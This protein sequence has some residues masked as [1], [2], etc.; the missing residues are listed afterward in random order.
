MVKGIYRKNS[1]IMQ[2][3][4]KLQQDCFVWFHNTYPNLRGTM[5][6]VHNNPKNARHGTVL[7]GLGLVAGVSDMSFL[8][9]GKFYAIEFKTDK[10][11]Q[12]KEQIDWEWTIFLQDGEY[13]IIRSFDE[14]RTFVET[15]LAK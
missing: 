6:L 10:G 11:K 12:S 5:W 1:N 15:T 7:K 8:Y 14:F 3:E 13:V 9:K 2:S 4:V